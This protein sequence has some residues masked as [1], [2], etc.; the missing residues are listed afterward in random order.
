VGAKVGPRPRGRAL[1]GLQ[2]ND[3]RVPRRHARGGD[4]SYQPRGR[5]W[6]LGATVNLQGKEVV[7]SVP[8]VQTRA[9]GSP[10]RWPDRSTPLSSGTVRGVRGHQDEEHRRQT[11]AGVRPR[12]IKRPKRTSTFHRR[13]TRAGF[14][15]GNAAPDPA[16][17]SIAST[18]PAN[19][20][21]SKTVIFAPSRP[22][23]RAL[24][25]RARADDGSLGQKRPRRS[26]TRWAH[27]S[28]TTPSPRREVHS[29]TRSRRR[30]FNP[31]SRDR[32]R[33]VSFSPR[34]SSN[35][36]S[37]RSPVLT[38]R[39]KSRDRSRVVGERLWRS[40]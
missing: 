29:G 23:W 6:R 10:S 38:A 1:G 35:P 11:A 26:R 22:A 2:T 5:A 33:T 27:G 34:R 7:V 32:T 4:D 16:F 19:D 15:G 20:L 24:R 17:T 31:T 21:K 28:S 12:P 36:A 3:E 25:P 13:T 14:T 39:V 30:T 8:G 9:Q 40:R 37:P 18:K